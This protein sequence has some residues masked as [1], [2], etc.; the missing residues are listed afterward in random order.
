MLSNS[1][2]TSRRSP[3]LSTEVPEGG[4][5]ARSAVFPAARTAQREDLTNDV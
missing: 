5:P 1:N 2:P 4:F 3:S